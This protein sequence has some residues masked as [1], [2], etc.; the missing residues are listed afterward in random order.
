M[1]PQHPLRDV[2]W[3]LP[4]KGWDPD[5][6]DYTDSLRGQWALRWSLLP[7]RAAEW[8]WERMR[9]LVTEYFYRRPLKWQH[10]A[11][12]RE[13]WQQICAGYLRHIAAT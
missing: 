4:H 12:T 9:P 3:S 2:V 1:D 5:A 10:M 8:S 11:A 7:Q 13:L 6:A